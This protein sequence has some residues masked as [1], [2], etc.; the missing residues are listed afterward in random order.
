MSDSKDIALP[1][2]ETKVAVPA[3][4]VNPAVN[5]GA[6][7]G[8]FEPKVA[9]NKLAGLDLNSLGEPVDTTVRTEADPSVAADA[10]VKATEIKRQVTPLL[11]EKPAAAPETGA[12]PLAVDL[13][14][15]PEYQKMRQDYREKWKYNGN[16]ES[17]TYNKAI[18]SVAE[19]DYRARYPD[20]ATAYDSKAQQEQEAAH[21]ANKGAAPEGQKVKLSEEQQKKQEKLQ[22]KKQKLEATV[23]EGK[24][25]TDEMNELRNVQAEQRGQ[26]EN[27]KLA[28]EKKTLEQ[29]LADGTI[30]GE[31]HAKLIGISEQL[32][33][34]DARTP[35]QKL[36]QDMDALAAKVVEQGDFKPEDLSTFLEKQAQFGTKANEKIVKGMH[37]E[38]IKVLFSKDT[39][40]KILK[41]DKPYQYTQD[42]LAMLQQFAA[43]SKGEEILSAAMS[44][45]IENIDK[46]KKEV[47]KAHIELGNNRSNDENVA[48]V[49]QADYKLALLQDQ[50]S[51]Q[52]E[53]YRNVQPQFEQVTNDILIRL[54]M[55]KSPLVIM[56]LFANARALIARGVAQLKYKTVGTTGSY[57]EA[58][59][60]VK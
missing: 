32:N 11:A 28:D 9:V 25:S 3:A 21:A 26:Q 5:L 45:S 7:L 17:D 44:Q 19:E 58:K 48:A 10:T 41:L 46:A 23:R 6:E 47:E 54:G 50:L 4:A 27:A 24:A 30:S 43:L 57:N 18:D 40:D 33:P 37:Q 14:N 1:N 20:R 2:I 55:Q 29:K 31:E 59:R 49:V 39:L 38:F 16:K 52:L 12:K 8:K 22:E 35:E 15:D 42:T 51:Q 34:V 56:I 53:Q 36:E 13:K 60:I